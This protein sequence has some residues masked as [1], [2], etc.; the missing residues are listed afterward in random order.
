MITFRDDRMRC[1]ESVLSDAMR[2][3]KKG[4]AVRDGYQE[5]LD[6]ELEIGFKSV[7]MIVSRYIRGGELT[8][9]LEPGETRRV[10]G[11]LGR[12]AE[13]GGRGFEGL[14]GRDESGSTE[15]SSTS[16]AGETDADETTNRVNKLRNR[17]QGLGGYLSPPLPPPVS[18]LS[19]SIVFRQ[20][21]GRDTHTSGE[22]LMSL[23][24]SM[25]DSRRLP[26]LTPESRCS[27]FRASHS[28][29]VSVSL[30]P[31][32]QPSSQIPTTL[33]M[34]PRSNSNSSLARG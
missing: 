3:P 28:S 34:S 14:E 6:M 29:A 23:S 5:G 10:G 11:V 18:V 17:D 30:T 31:V 22:R 19:P 24:L 33:S 2:S 26:L 13:G 9:V 25:G 1:H 15:M 16:G 7:A 12:D 8:S 21:C 27:A 20:C 4:Y 32:A